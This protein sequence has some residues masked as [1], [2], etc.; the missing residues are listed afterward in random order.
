MYNTS[1]G[2][3]TCNG[4]LCDHRRSIGGAPLASLGGV[5]VPQNVLYCVISF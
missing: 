3:M 5:G 2:V 1:K 4:G